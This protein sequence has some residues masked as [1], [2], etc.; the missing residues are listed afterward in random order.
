VTLGEDYL[1]DFDPVSLD[2][3]GVNDASRADAFREE[4]L[5]YIRRLANERRRRRRMRIVK[6]V[7]L[8][9]SLAVAAVL[10][11]GVRQAQTDADR[12]ISIEDDR[13]VLPKYATG[14]TGLSRGGNRVTTTMR[15]VGGGRLVHS[16]YVD[17]RKNVCASIAQVVR[18]ITRW[19]GGGGCMQPAEI[20]KAISHVPSY[21]SGTSAWRGYDLLNGYGRADLARVVADDSRVRIQSTISTAW[22]PGGNASEEF[23]VKAFLVRIWHGPGVRFGSVMDLDGLGRNL[24][25]TAVLVNG[26]RAPI[27]GFDEALHGVK[28]PRQ[29]IDPILVPIEYDDCI[30]VFPGGKL[31]PGRRRC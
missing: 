19:E 7:G 28:P 13:L 17:V 2:L 15:E 4:L 11:S 9:A 3:S 5:T 20:A 10:V 29:I 22:H 14:G 23:A 18:G 31:P 6:L 1:V 24:G 27:V 12:S 21:Y 26:D 8:G 16:A 30:I 25:L